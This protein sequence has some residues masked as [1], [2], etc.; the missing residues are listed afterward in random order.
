M[1]A[2]GQAREE[3][4]RDHVD[5]AEIRC[6][7]RVRHSAES[8]RDFLRTV[9]ADGDPAHPS[10]A[11]SL[12]LGAFEVVFELRVLQSLESPNIGI[13]DLEQRASEEFGATGALTDADQVR[14]P[15]SE[16]LPRLG[17]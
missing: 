12:P 11:P 15:L 2:V 1:V 8:A 16:L 7:N 6:R 13:A 9:D 10:A 3:T 14:W 4:I 5:V 17:E